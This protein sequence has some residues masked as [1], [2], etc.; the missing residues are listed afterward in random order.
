MLLSLLPIKKYTHRINEILGIRSI[1]NDTL[2]N[3]WHQYLKFV[4]QLTRVK[5]FKIKYPV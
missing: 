3:F 5:V 1:K 4:V 2:S